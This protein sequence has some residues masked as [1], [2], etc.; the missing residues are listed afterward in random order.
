MNR[1]YKTNNCIICGSK[2]KYWVGHVLASKQTTVGTA[3]RILAGFCENHLN[4]AESNENGCYGKFD[5][6]L[7]KI[8]SL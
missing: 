2:A 3:T 5:P 1:A 6:D 4:A 7:M 8:S